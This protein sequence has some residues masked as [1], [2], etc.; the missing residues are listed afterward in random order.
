MHEN[1][2]FRYK[3][4][5][6][7]LTDP[8]SKRDY[9][10]KLFSPVSQ[11]YPKITRILS[12]G[13]DSSW[14]RALVAGLPD[15]SHPRILDIACG[16]GDLAF[17]LAAR[18]PDATI[19]GVDLNRDMLSK[20]AAT[21]EKL[22]AAVA[23]RLSFEAG[24]MNGLAFADESFDM[25]TGGYALRN[26]PEIDRTLSEIQRLLKPGGTAAFLDFSKSPNLTLRRVQ[27]GLLSFWGRLWGRIYHGNPEV[28]GYIAES[29]EAFP[30]QAALRSRFES[31]GFAVR[32][33]KPLM[34]GMLR[35]TLVEKSGAR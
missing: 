12:F 35:I 5:D 16:P 13:R 24:D 34:F 32:L 33:H 19:T 28:Y 31:R 29:L 1:R 27:L 18:Y 17:L 22:P 7:D 21:R 6:F 11:V 15:L 10:Q 26:S 8:E 14:K 25:V 23:K 3:F 4:T 20:A 2:R 30:D 9:N